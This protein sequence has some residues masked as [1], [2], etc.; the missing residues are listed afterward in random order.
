MSKSCKKALPA[1][2]SKTHLFTLLPIIFVGIILTNK[3]VQF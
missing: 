1:F 3:S 2:P